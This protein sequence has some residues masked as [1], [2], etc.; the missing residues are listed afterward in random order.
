MCFLPAARQPGERTG[1]LR[2]HAAGRPGFRPGA[3]GPGR[4][5]PAGGRRPPPS[6]CCPSLS[7]R[8]VR[9]TLVDTDVRG[10]RRGEWVQAPRDDAVVRS[11][12]PSTFNGAF[13]T[14]T[15]PLFCF[16][17]PRSSTIQRDALATEGRNTYSNIVLCGETVA[18]G[19]LTALCVGRRLFPCL[20]G[21][22]T[23]GDIIGARERGAPCTID[24]P[25]IGGIGHHP[26]RQ[27]L[28]C[29]P[30]TACHPANSCR[31]ES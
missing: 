7:R 13:R 24:V 16:L 19:G 17:V 14:P 22:I 20:T 27:D 21:V 30:L 15:P 1:R 25:N 11:R 29:Q 9:V 23:N 4:G 2:R 3:A 5:T 12:P 8:R 26:D 28:F 18:Q 31:T 6:P 10:L